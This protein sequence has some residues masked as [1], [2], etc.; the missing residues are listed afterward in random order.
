MDPEGS[1]IAP[2]EPNAKFHEFQ[3]EGIGYA[4]LPRNCSQNDIV[5]KWLKSNDK[6][7]FDYARRLIRE[8]GLLVGGSSGAV[9][10]G[11]LQIAK[12]LN[13]DSSK[14]IV[15]VFADSVRNY[16]TKFLNDDWL[17]ERGFLD[18]GI[19]DQK[20]IEEPNQ[21]Y[22]GESKIA[23]LNLKEVKPITMDFTVKQALKEFQNQ[24]L[25]CVFIVDFYKI[26]FRN[27]I[28]LVANYQCRRQAR[29]SNL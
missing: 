10:W 7:T 14:R 16:I 18:Q 4:F 28:K 19:Y 24:R 25:D 22:G 9:L 3:V 12:S 13:L 27:L 2:H 20:Y 6:T 1:L 29:R 5:D 21:L 26:L 17:L 8:E 15:C 11:A 23:D